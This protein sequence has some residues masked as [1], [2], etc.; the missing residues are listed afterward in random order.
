[1]AAL[2][3]LF[4]KIIESEVVCIHQKPL[5]NVGTRTHNPMANFPMSEV[6]ELVTGDTKRKRHFGHS[7]TVVNINTS[8]A[9]LGSVENSWS[10]GLGSKMVDPLYLSWPL[11]LT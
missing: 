3:D 11:R 6:D 2:D 5:C 10:R 4:L 1:M 7:I 9:F 8:F